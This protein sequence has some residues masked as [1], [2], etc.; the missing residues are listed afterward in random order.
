[1]KNKKLFA[2]TLWLFKGKFSTNT[3]HRL[4]LHNSIYFINT[5][6]FTF[7]GYVYK[8]PLNKIKSF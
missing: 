1:M 8:T 3:P 7:I 4:L 2:Y 6:A 5:F